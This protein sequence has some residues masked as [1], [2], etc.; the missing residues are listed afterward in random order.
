M[1]NLLLNRFDYFLKLNVVYYFIP[2]FALSL[3]FIIFWGFLHLGYKKLDE[4]GYFYYILFNIMVIN[5][6]ILSIFLKL[7]FRI[8]Y[9]SWI[10]LLGTF[11]SFCTLNFIIF[12]NLILVN[13]EVKIVRNNDSLFVLIDILLIMC[14]LCFTVLLGLYLDKKINGIK[15]IPLYIMVWFFNTLIIVKMIV[16]N[17]TITNFFEWKKM[18]IC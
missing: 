2:I 5:C 18:M 6:L 11:C 15:V 3:I 7:Q 13:K 10:T 8:D 12:N 1:I 4:L 17:T 14:F 16:K 9:I